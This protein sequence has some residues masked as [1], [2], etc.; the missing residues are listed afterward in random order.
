VEGYPRRWFRPDLLSA[1]TIGAML[2]PQGLAYAQI[3]GVRP[4]AGLYA[5]AAAMLAYAL[6]GPSRHL[7]LGPEAGAAIL[8]ATALAPLT[9]GAGP[10]RLA[11]LAALLAV[12]VAVISLLAGL[13]RAGALADFLSKPILIGYTNGAALIIIGSQLARMFG[14]ERDS[15]AFVGQVWEVGSNLHRTHV[16]TLLLGLGILAALVALRRLL[17]RLPGPLLLVVLTTVVAELLELRQG[18]L[19]VVGA[20]SAEPPSLGLPELRFDDFRALL[21]AAFS[22]ALVNYAGSVLAGRLYADRNH[23]RIDTNQEFLGQAASNLASS[24]VQGFPVTGSDSR[25]AVNDAMGGRSQ[26]VGVLAAVLVTVFALFLTPLLESLPLVTL[27]AIVIVAAVYL[28]D[29]ASVAT[30]WRTRRVEALLALATTLGV[31]LLGILQGILIA[32]ALALG[33]L[34][35][36]AAHP[37]D[38]V[39]G[40]REELPGWHDL[41]RHEGAR[42][43]PGLLVYRFD[44]PMFFANAR[45]LRERVRELV[46]DS[47]PPVEEVILDASSVYDLDVTA[48]EGL[49]KLRDELAE[50]DV[51]LV[52]AEANAPLRGMLR[53]TGL[54]DRLGSDHVYLTVE[55]AVEGFLESR[56]AR[57]EARSRADAPPAPPM[58]H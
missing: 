26:L 38:A 27:A 10:E 9:A 41:T 16:P 4:V 5:G 2:V 39:L 28:M 57:E 51:T 34:I 15:D 3:V 33:D 36:R 32:V 7:M 49:A 47:R 14:L 17:P 53:R 56:E 44:A 8:S 46:A 55:E 54:M 30:L 35:R 50:R 45:H 21:P 42:P 24:L 22:L 19:Q 13:F 40:V 58:T 52:I 31:L 25:T 1:L 6:F 48:A 37:H 18:G 11:S 23:Y 20:I 43:I 12:M 29:F